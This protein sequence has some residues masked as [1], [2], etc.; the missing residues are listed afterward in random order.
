MSTFNKIN[1][2]SYLAAILNFFAS[3]PGIY[4]QKIGHDHWAIIYQSRIFT[5]IHGPLDGPKIV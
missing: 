2:K 1:T 5:G 3:E 4:F